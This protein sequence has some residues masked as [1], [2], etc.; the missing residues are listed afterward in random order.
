MMKNILKAAAVL[1][2]LVPAGA[3]HAQDAAAGEKV[4]RKCKACHVVDKEQNRVGP[5]LVG[6]IGRPVA[7]IEDFRYSSAMEEWGE[8]KT[9]DDALFLEY[10]EK[11][12]TMVKGTKMAFAGLRD[13]QERKD[14]LAYLKEA[15]AGS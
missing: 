15:G 2:V 13:E 14:I 9:W 8:G 7:A 12:R 1:S 6:I 4:F 10:I 3:A 11:P 5:H